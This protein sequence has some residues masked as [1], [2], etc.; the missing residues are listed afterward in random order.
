VECVARGAHFVL[1]V[2]FCNLRANILVVVW[3]KPCLAQCRIKELYRFSIDEWSCLLKVHERAP[4]IGNNA[5][6]TSPFC[7]MRASRHRLQEEQ[8]LQ[9]RDRKC[10]NFPRE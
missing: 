9:T 8:M 4:L 6:A 7:I 10:T 1:A 5:S 3:V 2:P